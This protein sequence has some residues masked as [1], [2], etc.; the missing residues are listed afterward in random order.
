MPR[1]AISY[2]RSDSSA[3]AGRI[4]DR[5]TAHYGATA[6]FMDIDGIPFGTDF[7]AHVRKALLE[8]EV[9]VAVIGADWIGDGLGAGGGARIM[10]PMDPVRIE[11]ETALEHGVL[12][13]PAL[14][15]GAKMPSR[16]LLPAEFGN[17]AFL[18]AVDVASGRDFSVHINRLI[19]AIDRIAG[20][21]APMPAT[22]SD[23]RQPVASDS[24]A[25]QRRDWRADAVRYFFAPL[26]LLLVAH[27]VIVNALDLKTVYLWASAVVVP[28]AF[29]FAFFWSSGGG[30]GAATGLAVM[31]GVIGDAGMTISVGLNSG[32]SILPQTRV[33]WVDNVQFTGAIALSFVAGNL[34]AR[35]LQ[36]R[37]FRRS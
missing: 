17:F 16:D 14:V 15:D 3:M 31:L 21:A 9:L 2:R 7:R 29:G 28:F 26:V 6:V 8:T 23:A 30:A 37:I 34:L 13:I 5:L 12:I 10:E 19:V 22:P 1:I 24:K 36:G 4:F 25:I 18:N 35:V 11:I 33:D 20:A 32:D 27:H